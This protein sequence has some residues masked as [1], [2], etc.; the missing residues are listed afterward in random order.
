MTTSGGEEIAKILVTVAG[1][2][3]TGLKQNRISG[4][5]PIPE[6]SSL[7]LLGGGLIGLAGIVGRKRRT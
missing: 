6:S 1:G 7:L 5:I 4:V 3:V 2:G